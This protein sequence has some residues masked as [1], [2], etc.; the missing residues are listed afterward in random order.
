MIVINTSSMKTYFSLFFVIIFLQFSI[1]QDLKSTNLEI[2]RFIDGTLLEPTEQTKT[3]AI[4][5]AGSGPT[6]RD[7]NSSVGKN[8]SLKLLAQHLAENGIASFRYDKRIL[9]LMRENRLDQTKLRFEDFVKDAADVVNYFKLYNAEAYGYKK[10]IL[11]GH[12]QGA[13]VAQL[14]SLKTAVTGLV[15]VCGSSRPIKDIL[16]EQVAKQAPYLI[17]DLNTSLDSIA[18]VGYVNEIN[19]LLNTLL[20]KDVQPFLQSWMVHDPSAIARKIEEPTLAIGGTTDIQVPAEEAKVLAEHL[21]NGQYA[22]IDNMNH[23]LKTIED[24][25]LENQKSYTNPSLP[26]S[27][28][29]KTELLAFIKSL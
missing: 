17:N 12:S 15:L 29:F 24:M 28:E 27:T 13:L 2:N 5:I 26:L 11:I 21:Q 9:K 16:V 8:N 3:L 6:N 10:F 4:I 7:G 20:Y 1:A 22:I 14:A 19:P 23:V 18:K 25:G